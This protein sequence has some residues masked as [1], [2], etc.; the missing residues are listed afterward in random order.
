MFVR[1]ESYFKLYIKKIM[2]FQ[3]GVILSIVSHISFSSKEQ[4]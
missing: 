1:S 3:E 4:F 2:S